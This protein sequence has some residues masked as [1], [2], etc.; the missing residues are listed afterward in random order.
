M[1]QLYIKYSKESFKEKPTINDM[2]KITYN[3]K[4]YDSTII[5]YKDL[6]TILEE[7]HSILLAKFKTG[8]KSIREEDIECIN[9]IALDIDSKINKIH[10]YEMQTLIYKKLGIMPIIAYPTFSDTDLTKFRLIY[11]FENPVDVE[12]FRLFYEAIAWKFKKYID[13]ATKNANRIWAGTNKTVNFFEKDLPITLPTILKLINAYSKSL[14]KYEKKVIAVKKVSY[15]EFKDCD[16]IKSEYK[17]EVIRLIIDNIKLIDFIY[18]K[19]GGNF[20]RIS[21]RY[22]GRCCL[23]GGDNKNALV[24]T[25]KT[26]RCYTHCGTGNIFTLAK[27]VY[28]ITNFSQLAF[29]LSEEYR[30]AIPEEYIKRV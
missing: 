30:I 4:C 19:F 9:C 15:E 24:I 1:K 6:K 25:G 27:K 14:K 29:R 16:Y 18:D 21:N 20:K 13:L 11:R 3:L 5:S 2:V 17:E 10:L 12:T 28:G 8:S 26:Y 23:H 7:G 22:V